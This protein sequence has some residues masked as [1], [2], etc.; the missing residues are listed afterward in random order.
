M[1]ARGKSGRLAAQFHERARKVAALVK[2]VELKT[3]EP[4]RKAEALERAAELL[5]TTLGSAHLSHLT[6]ESIQ[7]ALAGLLDAG[8]AR[9]SVNHYRAAICAFC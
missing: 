6:S 7:A 9:Q 8:K 1:E 5:A 2:G 3:L 4:G